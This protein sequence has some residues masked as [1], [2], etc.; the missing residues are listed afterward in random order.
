MKNIKVLLGED[1]DDWGTGI[2]A[3]FGFVCIAD[4][5][6]GLIYIKWDGKWNWITDRHN[7]SDGLKFENSLSSTVK[8]AF[9]SEVKKQIAVFM[10]E[11]F[12]IDILSSKK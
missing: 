1:G 5:P 3:L 2:T 12:E 6:L 4:I 7:Q 10:F 11:E 9:Y 8:L